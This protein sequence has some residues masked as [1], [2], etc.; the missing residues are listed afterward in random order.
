MLLS[1]DNV[2][3]PVTTVSC[4]TRTSDDTGSSSDAGG[5]DTETDEETSFPVYENVPDEDPPTDCFL[6]RTH[7][8]GPCREQWRSFEF[9]AKDHPTEDGSRR[10]SVYAKAFQECWVKHLNLYLLIAMTLNEERVQ[11]IERE[12]TSSSPDKECANDLQTVFVWQEWNALLEQDGFFESC[13]R[14]QAVFEEFDRS[15][16]IWKVY[17]SLQEEP[18]VVNI[19]CQIPSRRQD[20]R[21]LKVVYGLDQENRVV[22]LSDY[23][24]RYEIEK[25]EKQGKEPDLEYHRFVISLVPGVTEAVQIKA[26]YASEV[27]EDDPEEEEGVAT[28]DLDQAIVNDEED[29]GPILTETGWIPLPGLNTPDGFSYT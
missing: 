27:V 1:T 26:V 6:C 20:G 4:E 21:I 5:S 9:C 12:F 18:F 13:D 28:E 8:R 25:A 15:V 14:V 2:I 16:P 19:P 7:R 3:S 10:C 24:P 11:Q 22:G 23:D 29:K 17:N